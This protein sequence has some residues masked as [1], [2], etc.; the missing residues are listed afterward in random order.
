MNAACAVRTNSIEMYNE[1]G[2][3]FWNLREDDY[4][5]VMEN[6]NKMDMRT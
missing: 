4:R 2:M 1:M 6:G 5:Y 3:M